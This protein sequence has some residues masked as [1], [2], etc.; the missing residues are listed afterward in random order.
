MDSGRWAVVGKE[1]QSEFRFLLPS[2]L[3]VY[4]ARING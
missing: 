4:D 1:M 3:L 2:H